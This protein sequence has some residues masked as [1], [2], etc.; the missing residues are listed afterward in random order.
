[1]SAAAVTTPVEAR[2]ARSGVPSWRGREAL[3]IAALA[4]TVATGAALALAGRVVVGTERHVIPDWIAGPLAG[5]AVHVN[6]QQFFLAIGAMAA[7][8]AAAI[9][10]APQLRV[11]WIVAAAVAL[12]VLFALTPPLLSTDVFN[13]VMYGRMGALHGLDPYAVSPA[14]LVHDP[15]YHYIAWRHTRS[16]YGPLFTLASY[17]IARLGPAGALWTFKALA[18]AANAGCAALVWT[19]AR[20][21]GR[22]PRRALAVFALN[23]LLLVWT[24]GGGHNDLL[25]LLGLLGAIALVLSSREALGGAALVAGVAIKAS[26]GLAAPFILLGA[27]RRWR[28]LAGMAGAAV[29]VVTVTLAFFPSH[30]LGLLLVLRHD[31]HLVAFDGIPR[32]LSHL[33]G[34]R[35]ETAV[36]RAAMTGA[37]LVALA[38]QLVRSARGGDWIAGLGWAFVALIATSSWYL[39]WYT[40]W[41]LALAAV[42]RD[43]RL[44]VAVLALQAYFVANHLPLFTT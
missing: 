12:D 21:L 26:A 40:I 39:A 7:A 18:A 6:A 44:V 27:R 11:R 4:G 16:A 34:L 30:G 32:E 20:R 37:F 35:G 19:I 3:A 42:T 29:V 1:M 24:V 22:S 25:M 5:I 36:V 2:V 41:P 13:Y 23:P 15:L 43:R 31:E 28:A 9:A 8:Y 14:R 10:L 33:F 38:F 17:P